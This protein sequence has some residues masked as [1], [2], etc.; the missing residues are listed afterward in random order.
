MIQFALSYLGWAQ[1]G[2][3]TVSDNYTLEFLIACLL[4]LHGFFAAIGNLSARDVFAY[5][6]SHAAKYGKPTLFAL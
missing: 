3:V 4:E 1:T 6:E 2:E 5:L